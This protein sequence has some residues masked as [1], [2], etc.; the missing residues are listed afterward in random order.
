[1]INYTSRLFVFLYLICLTSLCVNAQLPEKGDWRTRVGVKDPKRVEE[2]MQ[3]VFNKPPYSDPNVKLDS[4]GYLNYFES[5]TRLI[6]IAPYADYAFYSGAFSD[7]QRDPRTGEFVKGDISIYDRLLK[8]ISDDPAVKMVLMDDILTI[9]RNFVDNLDSVNIV[10]NNG[11]TNLKSADDTLSLPVAMT[12]Y[13][14]LYYRYAGNP[15]YYPAHL[16]DKV[17]ARENYREAF[18]ILREKNINP[19]D[20][21][22]AFYIREYYDVCEELFLSDEEKYY[23]QFLEDYLEVILA[24]DN[25]LNPF[26]NIPD[27][28]KND[29]SNPKYQKYR[30][31]NTIAA[32]RSYYIDEFTGDS[33]LSIPWRF[34]RSGAATKERIENFY[35]PRLNAHRKD[36]TFLERA[37][38]LMTVNGI[39][40]GDVYF[41][42]CQA[43]YILKKTYE[44]CIGSALASKSYNMR[45]DMVEKFLEAIDVA[46]TDLERGIVAFLIGKETNTIRP[47][48]PNDLDEEGK[49]QVYGK[50]TPEFAEWERNMV[51]SS[52]NLKNVLEMQEVFMNSGAENLR[53]YPAHAAYELGVVTYRLAGVNNSSKEC[54]DAEVYIR[55]A[56][57]MEPELY[58]SKADDMIA[59]IQDAYG[60]YLAREERIS[61]NARYRKQWE[62]QQKEY[63]EKLARRKAEEDFWKQ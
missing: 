15:E 10:R 63:Q 55:M 48:N 50:D 26:V 44:N 24:C 52:A 43:S 62:K 53:Q 6:N 45:Q 58:N 60:K 33:V 8:N 46:N 21:L 23:D 61:R 9:G 13:A 54:K 42:Y 25:I 27:S 59:N 47:R 22:H 56:K 57:Q 16:Y 35:G 14:H 38:H 12:K 19:G 11:A 40:S 36:T 4:L 5:F 1:M 41:D 31:F 30:E 32:S 51:I 49:A 3:D 20:E 2:L 39:M 37:V 28:I 18:R 34:E 17:Q 7:R 29:A